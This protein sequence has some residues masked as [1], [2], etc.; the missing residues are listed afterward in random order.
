MDTINLVP[1]KC[2][3]LAHKSHIPTSY[4]LYAMCCAAFCSNVPSAEGCA[5][6]R[7]VRTS[8]AVSSNS[9]AVKKN[10]SGVPPATYGCRSS[11]SDAPKLSMIRVSNPKDFD[12]YLSMTKRC[13]STRNIISSFSRRRK[14]IFTGERVICPLLSEHNL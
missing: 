9:S 8:L 3:A 12:M 1:T 2:H 10:S 5:D 13:R 11:T 6:G 14:G 7:D 4:C